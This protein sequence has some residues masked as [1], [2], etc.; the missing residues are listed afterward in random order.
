MSTDEEWETFA[1]TSSTAGVW[2]YF[3]RHKSKA[4]SRCKLCKRIFKHVSSTTLKY[5]VENIHQKLTSKSD[6]QPGKETAP[7]SQQKSQPKIAF[8]FTKQEKSA[9]FVVSRLAAE[10]RISFGLIA[11]SGEMRAGFKARN[12]TVPGT[13]NGVK[14]MVFRYADSVRDKIKEE[15]ATRISNNERFS[16]TLDEYT[17]V[18]NQR[19]D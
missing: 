12:L 17:S 14:K 18:K 6:P 1:G 19:C 3:E 13:L 10:D 8:M 15:L 16:L 11:K 5:H 2:E 7:S 4:H 9:D